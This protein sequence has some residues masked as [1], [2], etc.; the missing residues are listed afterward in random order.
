MTLF[1]F[2]HVDSHFAGN[3]S[4]ILEDSQQNY[5]SGCSYRRILIIIRKFAIKVVLTFLGGGIIYN[6]GYF[7]GRHL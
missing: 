1:L 3:L 2:G 6:A 7:A 4:F 5:L